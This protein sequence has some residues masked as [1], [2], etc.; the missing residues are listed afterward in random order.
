MTDAR[1]PACTVT[2]SAAATLGASA[3]P[4]LASVVLTDAAP[5]L[6]LALH[7]GQGLATLVGLLPGAPQLGGLSVPGLGSTLAGAGLSAAGLTVRQPVA[8]GDAYEIAAIYGTVTYPGW[9][10]LLPDGFPAP[11]G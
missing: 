3:D 10:S 5:V 2:L 7:D 11:A 4:A 6:D 8:G 1:L 9:T